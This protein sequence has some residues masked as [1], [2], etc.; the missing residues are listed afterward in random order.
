MILQPS[1]AQEIRFVMI[2]AAGVEVAGLG[3]AFNLFIGKSGAAFVAGTGTKAEISNG[4][5]SYIVTAAETDTPGPLAIYVTGAGAV[6]QNLI[7]D[8]RD[9]PAWFWSYRSRTLT[10]SLADFHLAQ[11]GMDIS[12]HRGDTLS[13]SLTYLG[14]IS[15]RSKLWFTVKEDKDSADTLADIQI[16]E[17]A[18][19]VYINKAA[20]G[21]PANGSITVTDAALGNLTITLAAVEAAKLDTT[22]KFTYDLQMLT[23]AG[24][25]TTLR[26]G[27]A[28]MVSDI[29]RS[30]T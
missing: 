17:T 23:A 13:L 3:N 19:L 30:V 28:Q 24:V 22:G 6:Q 4:W 12:I 5:Y 20:A 29:T 15:A 25:V 10:T 2:D 1:T 7:Y 14:D 18:G 9:L 8:V 16:E 27:K 26:Q 11:N 21:T